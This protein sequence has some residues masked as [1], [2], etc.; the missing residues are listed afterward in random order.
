MIFHN[1]EEYLH[2]MAEY[3][4]IQTINFEIHTIKDNAIR[5]W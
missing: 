5:E 1:N 4:D 2:D 3:R